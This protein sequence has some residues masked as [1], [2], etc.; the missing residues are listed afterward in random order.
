[1]VQDATVDEQQERIEETYREHAARMW[2]AV[3]S[4]AGDP[5]IASDAVAEA[6][7]RALRDRDQINDPA[8]WTWRVAFRLASAELKKRR[9]C[10]GALEERGYETPDPVPELM[11]ALRALSPSQRLAVVLHDYA[12]RPTHEVAELLGCS[13]ATVHVHLSQGR[14]RLRSLLGDDDA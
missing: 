14:R 9:G 11:A 6:F 7:A 1:V 5:E 13:R 8:A 2:R 10:A 12:D 3:F 4:F